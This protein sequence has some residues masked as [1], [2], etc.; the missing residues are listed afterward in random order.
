MIKILFLTKFR[1]IPKTKWKLLPGGFLFL[2]IIL[3]GLPVFGQNTQT[4]RG[5][6]VDE[7]NESLPGVSIIL[8]NT[9]TGTVTDIDG[10][11]TLTVPAG[12]QTL[13]VSFV[14]ME[15]QEVAVSGASSVQVSMKE[16]SQEIEEVV[17]VGYGQQRKESVVGAI[18]QTTGKVL[19][20]TGGVSNL[21]MALTG[22]LPGVVTI[23]STGMPGEED[24][25]IIIRGGGSW[26]SSEPLVLVD[27]IERPLNTVD[28]NSVETISVLKDASATAI[29][30]IRGANGVILITTKRGQEGKASINFNFSATAKV[31][32]QIPDKWDSYDALMLRNRVIEQELGYAKAENWEKMTPYDILQKY[33][34]PANVEESERYPNVDWKS[35]LLKDYAMSYNANLNI[36]GGTSF[37]KYFANLDFQNEGDLYRYWDNNRGYHPGYGFNRMNVRTNLDFTLTRTTT[38]RLNLSGSHGVK[39]SPR[40]SYESTLWQSIYGTAPDAFLPRYS[41]GVWGFYYPDSNTQL[42]ENSPANVS[43]KGIG[44]TTNDR[45]N[46]DFTLTQDLGMLLKGLSL[47]GVLS[48]DNSYSETNRGIND[49]ADRQNKWIDPG[50]GQTY[51]ERDRD[52]NSGFDWQESLEWRTSGGEVGAGSVFRK[53]YYSVQLNYANSFGKHNV[54]VMGNFIREQSTR[55]SNIPSYRENWVFRTTYDYDRKYLFEYNGSYNGSE[56]FAKEY[57]FAY[58]QSGAIGW[59]LSEESFIRNYT[60]KWL[61]LLKVRYSYGII[62]DDNVSGS[63]WLYMTSWAYGGSGSSNNN[64]YFR[65][66]TTSDH[67]RNSPYQFYR[68]SSVG[69]PDV[70]WE[71]VTKSN[72]GIEYSFFNR[73]VS[74]SVDIFKD[75]RRDIFI[76]AGNRS[77]PDYFGASPPAANLGAIDT[78]GFEVELKLAKTL[79]KELRL[80]NNWAYT[81]SKNRIIA[82]EDPE[83]YPDYRKQAGFPTDQSRYYVD[84]GYINNWDEVYGSTAHSTLDQQNHTV[85][86]YLI[87][88]FNGDGIID[89]NDQI[90]YGFS[91]S[92][93]NTFNV[94]FGADYKGWSFMVQFYGVTNVIRD[95]GYQS[96]GGARNTVYDEGTYWSIDNQNPDVPLPNWDQTTN[97]YRNGTRFMYDASYLRLKNAEISY[98]FNSNNSNW[99]RAIGMSSLRLYA[100]GNNLWL[101]SKMPDDREANGAGQ[102]PTMKRFNVGVRIAL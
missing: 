45:I 7:K 101:Y 42:N 19:E 24:P 37:V 72:F 95:V 15:T 69:N 64:N 16:S 43:N 96:L 33:R 25:R 71:T 79:G 28:I 11:F 62:G 39:K 75:K 77:V 89:N 67:S 53:L 52:T 85:G 13:V 78:K 99:V 59:L 2:W 76:S 93:Q 55:G 66:G 14:G 10:N 56:K 17:V 50:N 20:R 60:Q 86:K 40:A 29:F 87:L 81:R 31:A 84:A 58:F 35:A 8:K 38:L 1:Q 27:G 91:N 47:R 3:A 61:D 48:F 92:P 4:I 6:V 70:R 97:S 54:G 46:T 12:E 34:Y 80:R 21:G 68:E 57:R 94:E 88:D 5:K 41:D 83:L 36:S 102:Y 49:G 82:R 74:G 90:P 23:T 98:T 100:N 73:L 32:S 51:W 30:G 44:Y 26:N 63:R 65:D 18:T 22:N 9:N